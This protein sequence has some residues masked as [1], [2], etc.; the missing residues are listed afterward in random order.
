MQPQSIRQYLQT[1]EDLI[2][3]ALRKGN[4]VEVTKGL[5]KDILVSIGR[6]SLCRPH[7][8]AYFRKTYTTTKIS[9]K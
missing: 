9:S 1:Y 7:V 3:T 5:R 4:V 2:V 6:P 8:D